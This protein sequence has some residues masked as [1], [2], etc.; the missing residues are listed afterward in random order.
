MSLIESI[1]MLRNNSKHLKH[2]RQLT[3][4]PILELKQARK[5][6][7]YFNVDIPF[8]SSSA[9]FCHLGWLM[10]TVPPEGTLISLSPPSSWTQLHD[11][12]SLCLQTGWWMKRDFTSSSQQHSGSAADPE[13]LQSKI[14]IFLQSLCHRTNV[15]LLYLFSQSLLLI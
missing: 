15:F 9:P 11:H 1:F 4:L 3:E 14:Y 8:H 2:L 10:S 13:V 12:E 5:W 7:T 6:S